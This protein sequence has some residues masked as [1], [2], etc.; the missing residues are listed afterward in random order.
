M[1]GNT[2][3]D[4]KGAAPIPVGH[5][6]EVWLLQADA[7]LI[8][9]G[10]VGPVVRHIETGVVYGPSWAYAKETAFVEQAPP[11]ELDLRPDAVITAHF[12]ARVA[13]C[14]IVSTRSDNLDQATTLILAPD[15]A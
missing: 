14:R 11:V 4:F 10:N 5:R 9:T 3:I 13:Y 15:G 7:G 8:S 6:V 2:R 1:P 12:K